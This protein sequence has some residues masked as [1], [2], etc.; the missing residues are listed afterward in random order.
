MLFRHRPTFYNAGRNSIQHGLIF[1]VS[2]MAWLWFWSQKTLFQCKF[3]VGP[4]SFDAGPT[5]NQHWCGV[6]AIPAGEPHL[7]PTLSQP[8]IYCGSRRCTPLNHQRPLTF[9]RVVIAGTAVRRRG[10]FVSRFPRYVKKWKI[11]LHHCS[12]R[13]NPGRAEGAAISCVRG[14]HNLYLFSDLSN[15]IRVSIFRE[16]NDT[17]FQ[18]A[19]LLT[20]SARRPSYYVKIWHLSQFPTCSGWKMTWSGLKIQ[21]K[22]HVSLN[23]FYGNFRSKTLGCRKIKSVFG[24]VKWCCNASWGPKGLIGAQQM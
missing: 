3:N 2:Y 12:L 18:E 1:R 16:G 6:V 13:R 17:Y 20:L 14:A 22:Y 10:P 9:M 19:P 23:Q 8:G 7:H 15:F 24:D 4:A 11:A 5:L 21:E